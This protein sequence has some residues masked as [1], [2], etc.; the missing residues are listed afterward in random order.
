MN[1]NQMGGVQRGYERLQKE[2]ED[3]EIELARVMDSSTS[4]MNQASQTIDDLR[5][6]VAKLENDIR[7]MVQKAA[8]RELPAYRRQAEENLR[9]QEENERLR[10]A[11]IE[12]QGAS[13]FDDGYGRVC[14][15]VERTLGIDDMDSWIVSRQADVLEAC[16]EAIK[17]G[18]T[19]ELL[20]KIDNEGFSSGIAES[21]HFMLT[22]AK[23]LR[24][25]ADKKLKEE[26]L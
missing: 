10:N 6:L 7:V 17:Q 9:L 2:K 25:Q 22:C 12:T 20:R 4:L 16:A 26:S 13:A 21:Q 3:L 11:L 24:E 1:N 19:P 8:D 14:R 15:I 5:Q 18:Y 23:D